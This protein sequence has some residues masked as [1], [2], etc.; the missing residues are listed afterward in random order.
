MAWTQLQD[1]LEQNREARREVEAAPPETCPIDGAILRIRGDGVRDCSM[2]N[3]TWPEGTR[4]DN[5]IP[6]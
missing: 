4:I 5:R 1:M 3:Y 6:A 2:G